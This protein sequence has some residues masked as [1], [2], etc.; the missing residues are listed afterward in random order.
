MRAK[1]KKEN[2]TY[3]NEMQLKEYQNEGELYYSLEIQTRQ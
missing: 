3:K 1:K 2:Y